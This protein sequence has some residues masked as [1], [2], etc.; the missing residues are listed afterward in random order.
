MPYGPFKNFPSFK[1]YLNKKCLNKDPFFYA[2]YSKR[3][4]SFCGLARY[5]RIKPEIGTIEVG[6][7]TY[8]PNLQKTVEATETMYLMMKNVFDKLGYRRYE[9]KCQ[10]LNIKSKQAA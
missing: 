2:I 9:W 7:I 3:F 5:L 4:K 8:A 10:N 6:W 1:N